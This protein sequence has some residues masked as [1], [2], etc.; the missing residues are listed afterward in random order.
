MAKS[1][2]GLSMVMIMAMVMSMTGLTTMM[3]DDLACEDHD[4][5]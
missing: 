1:D 3:T 5:A 4:V 2:H